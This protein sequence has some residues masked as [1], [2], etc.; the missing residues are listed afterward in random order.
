MS[1][2]INWGAWPLSFVLV[3]MMPSCFLTPFGMVGGFFPTAELSEFVVFGLLT[4][5]CVGICAAL[6]FAIA[7]RLRT[8]AGQ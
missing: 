8:V 3:Y 5:V 1:L 7:N 6:E 2:Y 4:L